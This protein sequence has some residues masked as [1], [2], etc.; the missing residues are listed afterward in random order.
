VR[1][2]NTEVPSGA[3][4]AERSASFGPRSRGS[5]GASSR[6]ARCAERLGALDR[7]RRHPRP[8]LGVVDE[9]VRVA[10]APELNGLRAVMARVAE[11]HRDQQR[12]DVRGAL[13]G[14]G[15]LGER[16]APQRRG[17]GQRG[18]AGRLLEQQQ[19]A[20]R[21]HRH[22]PRVGLAEDVAAIFD[23]DLSDARLRDR[24][25][26]MLGDMVVNYLES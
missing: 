12:L 25:R 22:P 20:H 10:V 11:A 13:R 5:S 21:V 18:R 7:D 14:H 17:G 23:R 24:Y 19:R 3:A 15:Q 9:D 2:K 16:V 8:G 26:Q 1:Q 4:I 6:S